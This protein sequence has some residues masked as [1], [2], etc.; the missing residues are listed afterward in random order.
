MSLVW[1][2]LGRVLKK[3]AKII[4]TQ[5]FSMKGGEDAIRWPTILVPNDYVKMFKETEL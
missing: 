1:R 5:V 4:M 3:N 2:I